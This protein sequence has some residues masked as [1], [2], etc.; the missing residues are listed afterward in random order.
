MKWS[1]H[2]VRRIALLAVEG[3]DHVEDEDPAVDRQ[4][5]FRAAEIHRVA[6]LIAALLNAIDEA[7]RVPAADPDE[8][9]GESCGPGCRGYGACQ[10]GDGTWSIQ[11][12][13]TCTLY[14]DDDAAASVARH[15]AIAILSALEGFSFSDDERSDALA[16]LAN[17]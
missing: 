9:G 4:I 1:P 5:E 7:R 8:T 13:D 6:P 17:G 11:R 12:C 2:E 3:S 10:W 14:V 16:Q 15:E